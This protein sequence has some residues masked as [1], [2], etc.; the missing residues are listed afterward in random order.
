MTSLTDAFLPFPDRSP[1]RFAVN[2]SRRSNTAGP[3]AVHLDRIFHESF[4]ALY[5]YLQRLSG[6]RALAEDIAQEAFV[7]LFDRG[8]MPDEPVAWLITVATNLLRD[9]HRKSSRRLRLLERAG[10]DVGRSANVPDAAASL[11]Q[12]ER[13]DQVRAILD[14]LGV[15][16]RQALL[17]R[18]SG[19]SYREIAVA[20]NMPEA[21]VGTTLVR[22]GE[23]FRVLYQELHGEPD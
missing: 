18:H 3:F 19:F 4:P 7:R 23:A 9:D 12:S 20:L 21:S 22:A 5:R 6:D 10:D 14:R 15:R 13:R 11:V 2:A 17:L 8:E 16:D 1:M